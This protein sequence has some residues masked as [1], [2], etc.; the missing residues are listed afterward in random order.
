VVGNDSLARIGGVS[1]IRSDIQGTVSTN[2]V[3]TNSAAVVVGNNS[4][5]IIGGFGAEDSRFSGTATSN[6][7]ATNSC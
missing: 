6:T 7:S 3:A 5:A 1:A 4:R 2:T